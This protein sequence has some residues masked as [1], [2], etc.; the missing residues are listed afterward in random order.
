MNFSH[1]DIDFRFLKKELHFQLKMQ[2]PQLF[3]IIPL[4]LP[5][6]SNIKKPLL[7]PFRPDQG[8]AFTY[9]VRLRMSSGSKNTLR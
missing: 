4:F 6:S 7:E 2:N 3:Q 5:R 8:D 1:L 9:P